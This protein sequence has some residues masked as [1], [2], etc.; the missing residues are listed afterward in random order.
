ML[1]YII[2]IIFI[3]ANTLGFNGY[4][5]LPRQKALYIITTLI[6]VYI[7]LIIKKYPEASDIYNS[8][9]P[10]Y[11]YLTNVSFTDI[12]NGTLIRG[13][14]FETGYNIYVK[15]LTYISSEPQFLLIATF[16][17]LTIAFGVFVYKNSINPALAICFFFALGI[18]GLILTAL[19]QSLAMAICLFAY[20]AI[21]KRKLVHFLLLVFLASLFHQSAFFFLPAYIIGIQKLK[22]QNIILYVIIFIIG[23]T[24]TGE[25][26]KI[27]GNLTEYGDTY[28]ISETGNGL[29]FF[30]IMLLITFASL[31]FY[32]N[33]C[34]RNDYIN[35]FINI[36]IINLTLWGMRLITRSAERPSYYFMFAT[37]IVLD[38]YLST[39][40]PLYAKQII[41]FIITILMIALFLYRMSNPRFIQFEF[42]WN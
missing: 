12:F 35:I 39:I 8:Y 5:T 10:H 20:E 7:M 9:F 37:I 30:T 27:V 42:I 33:M 36:N 23:F 11:Q 28:G 26:I 29:E 16:L 2:I 22:W 40:K 18:H 24:Y 15:L 34:K 1:V 3:F 13:A 14:R 17:V 32:K 31:F 4:I 38:T 25:I 41:T 19:R 6:P 21:K